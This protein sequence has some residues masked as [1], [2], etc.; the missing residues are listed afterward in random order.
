MGREIKSNVVNVSCMY[1]DNV[2]I[3]VGRYI[4]VHMYVYM[5]ACKYPSY[6]FFE[7]KRPQEEDAGKE[8]N[9]IY[10]VH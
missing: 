4:Y 2:D 1:V 8:W 5:Y 3:Y 6:V 10:R 7:M 9:I